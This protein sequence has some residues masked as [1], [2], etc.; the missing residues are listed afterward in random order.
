M[1][2]IDFEKPEG[3]VVAL[4][5]QTAINLASRLDKAGI[6]IF[7][8]SSKSIDLA[9]DRDLFEKAMEEIDIPMPKGY[10]VFTLQDAIQ[11]ANEITYPVLVRPSFVL[12]GRMMHIVYDEE[13]LKSKV[14]EALEFDNEHPILVDKYIS[15]QECEVDAICDGKDVFI[16]GI[17][18]HIEKTGVHSGDSMS[19]YPPYSL[20][21]KVIDTIVKYTTAIGIKLQMIGLFNIQ[22]IVDNQDNVYII[23]VNPRSSR[24]V[25]FLAKST[26]VP[27]A[28][29]AT[30]VMLGD[31]LA[32]LGY[33]GLGQNRKRWYVKSPTFSF[34]KITG[35]DVVLSPEMKSTGEAIGYDI[36]LNRALYKSLR[37][38]GLRVSNYGTVL[39]TI[40][41]KQKEAALPLVKRFYDLGFNIEATEGTAKFLRKNGIKTRIKKKIS[42]G[43]EEILDSIKKGYV[44]YVINSSNNSKSTD[45]FHD[46]KIIRRA[47]IDNNVPVFTCLDTVKV[48]LDVLEEITM[49]VSVI[50]EE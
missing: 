31:K 7:G 6:K 14:T 39:V 10:G 32:D 21:Q 11:A 1:N 15:G 29:I 50:D 13:T 25:P 19:I 30:K 23:E 34:S 48:L 16:P 43:S 38:S 46:G 47:A 37:A 17:M 40:S 28:N 4:G 24:T 26:G 2:V 44:T 20:S 18:E 5:G 42:E 41:G 8:S 22:F 27:I 36:S 45:S 12:G 9:E 49:K 33:V 3:V 35:M